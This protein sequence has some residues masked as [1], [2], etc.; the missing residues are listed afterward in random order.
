[1]NLIDAQYT[2]TPFYGIRRMTAW[3]ATQGEP[4]NH[5][6][7]A[8]LMRVMGIEAIYAKPRTSL[9]GDNVR[10]YPYLLKGMKIDEPNQVWSTDITYLR[11]PQGF[12]YL[13]AILD[14]YSRYVLAWRVSNTMDVS[15]C[16]E[17]L[18]SA[19]DVG[20]PQIFNS[21]EVCRGKISP[22]TFLDQGAQFTSVAFTNHL[23]KAGIAISQDGKGRA[24]DN[25]FIERL[26]R[27]VKYEEVY[28]KEYYNVSVAL[29]SLSDYFDFYNH[30]SVASIPRVSNP[31]GST[32][33]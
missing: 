23:E 3:L 10:R 26:W 1:M 17:A 5:K 16:L 2:A 20:K 31:C 25:I 7:V 12:V 4:V 19:L 21:A 33:Q 29:R 11:L 9:P 22:A 24:F 8:R 18:E 30:S 27:S 15:F 6:R 32:F 28:L 14:W 13:V